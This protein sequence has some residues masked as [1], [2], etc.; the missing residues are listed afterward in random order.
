MPKGDSRTTGFRR[1]Q[2]TSIACH[3]L[4]GAQ[5]VGERTNERASAQ[6]NEANKKASKQTHKKER[7]D[8]G[9]ATHHVAPG[10]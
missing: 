7:V 6:T 4:N 10:R 9:H 2:L 3:L 5:G 1:L 8:D